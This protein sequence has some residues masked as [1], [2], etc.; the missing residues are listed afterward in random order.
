MLGSGCR[1]DVGCPKIVGTGYTFGGLS[2]P[3]N[4]S[5]ESVLPIVKCH[6]VQACAGGETASQCSLGYFDRRCACKRPTKS[7]SRP[8]ETLHLRTLSRL[9]CRLGSGCRCGRCDV[10]YYSL[11]GQCNDCGN[12]SLVLF[13]SRAIP[14]FGVGGTTAVFFFGGTFHSL[15]RSIALVYHRA[16]SIHAEHAN[17]FK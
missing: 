5:S 13:L 15:R 4:G 3:G 7:G 10:G 1:P 8:A 2:T 12:P 11:L 6:T 9:H 14:A 16:G 17:R